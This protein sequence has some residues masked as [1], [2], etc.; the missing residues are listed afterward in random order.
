[1]G[2]IIKVETQVVQGVNY[3]I[4]YKTTT[5]PIQVVVWSKPWEHFTK[6]MGVYR[7][8]SADEKEQ[9]SF[10]ILTFLLFF[11]LK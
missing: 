9:W 1:M 3:R 11:L 8:I 10:E 2:N 7:N 5:G 6:V 4:T